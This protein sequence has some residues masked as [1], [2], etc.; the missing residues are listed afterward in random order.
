MFRVAL[1]RTMLQ[2]HLTNWYKCE[3]LRMCFHTVQSQNFHFRC[4]RAMHSRYLWPT[5]HFFYRRNP[6]WSICVPNLKFLTSTVP[7]I[8]RGS[9]NS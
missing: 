4:L 3:S 9:Q 2:G 5:F 7:E 6:S 8:W 1:S